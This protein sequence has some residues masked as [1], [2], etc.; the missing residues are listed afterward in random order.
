MGKY[1]KEDN[2][3]RVAKVSKLDIEALAERSIRTAA[4]IPPIVKQMGG[5]LKGLGGKILNKIL[6]PT[7]LENRPGLL[8]GELGYSSGGVTKAIQP[9][10]AP[11]AYAAGSFIPGAQGVS[12]LLKFIPGVGP[13]LSKILQHA[14]FVT[15][16]EKYFGEVNRLLGQRYLITDL[17]AAPPAP[18]EIRLTLRQ[19]L[20]G[21]NSEGIV[22]I[23]NRDL[24]FTEAN[25]KAILADMQSLDKYAQKWFKIKTNAAALGFVSVD[26]YIEWAA[27]RPGPTKIREKAQKAGE[28]AGKSSGP[29]K[30]QTQQEF[31]AQRNKALNEMFPQ[32]A[33]K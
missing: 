22:S 19:I 14:D 6:K 8:P 16:G 1:F 28:K 5:K 7:T 15:S 13:T 21:L 26:A 23:A 9:G 4:S 25:I 12:K 29:T 2:N 11:G 32:G 27:S 10:K 33:P 30:V 3:Q 20:E 31:E 24:V 18:T 17:N